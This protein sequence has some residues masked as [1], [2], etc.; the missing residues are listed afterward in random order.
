M[1]SSF[2]YND[3]GVS[4]SINELKGALESYRANVATLEGYI[5]DISGSSSWQDESVK[6]SFVS[7]AQG[8]VSAYKTYISGI[9]GYIECLTKK[10]DNIAEH[11]SNFTK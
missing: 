5:T 3:S 6:T 9:E 10:S 1:A 7:A 8:Y 11:E 2:L 4:A